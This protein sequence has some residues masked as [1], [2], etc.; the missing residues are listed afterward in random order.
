MTTP[1]WRDSGVRS[2]GAMVLVGV[3]VWH[4]ARAWQL[5]VAGAAFVASALAFSAFRSTVTTHEG[6]KVNATWVGTAFT[7]AFWPLLIMA[8]VLIWLYGGVDFQRGVEKMNVRVARFFAARGVHAS[9]ELGEDGNYH[10]VVRPM[11][12]EDDVPPAVASARKEDSH[13]A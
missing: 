3:L 4:G 13:G 2:L 7:A 8:N 5:Y 12:D 9:T 6:E 10:Q 11:A 1:R